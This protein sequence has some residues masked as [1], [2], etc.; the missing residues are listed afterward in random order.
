MLTGTGASS[1]SRGP[2]RT[3]SRVPS[4]SEEAVSPLPVRAG[5]LHHGGRRAA[6]LPVSSLLEALNEGNERTEPE[7]FEAS[8]P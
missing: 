5:G 4:I 6:T 3:S 7:T 1:P 2:S 8:L